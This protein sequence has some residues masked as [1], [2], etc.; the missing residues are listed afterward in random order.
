MC[1]IVGVIAGYS[2]GFTQDE[3][4]IFRDMLFVDTLRGRDSTGVFMVTNKGNVHVR[5]AAVDGPSFIKTDEFTQLRGDSWTKGMFMVGHNRA[6]TRGSINDANA[7][8]FVVDD[9]I[10]LVQN[11]TYFGSHKHHKD[12]EVD[13]EAV[14]HVIAEND[15]IEEALQKVNA[16]YALVWYNVQ[17]STL[18][19]IRNTHRPLYLAKTASDTYVFASESES[20]WYACARASV[21]LKGT[22]KMLE[23][24][25]LHSF[26][27]DAASKTYEHE[28]SK[29]DI[30]FRG[31]GNSWDDEDFYGQ[32]QRH[33][34][35]YAPAN[36][37]ITPITGKNPVA[38]AVDNDLTIYDYV[39][40]RHQFIHYALNDDEVTPIRVK[41]DNNDRTSRIPVELEG[42]L[43]MQSGPN[44]NRWIVYGKMITPSETDPSPLIYTVM[45]DMTE[46]EVLSY[47][48]DDMYTAHKASMSVLHTI[49]P[50]KGDNYQIITQF[51]ANFLPIETIDEVVTNEQKPH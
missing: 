41:L 42:Y 8:P 22:P 20:I 23:P 12:T 25:E 2:N 4:N 7:H 27:F 40:K 47:V 44:C 29:L 50:K 43:P 45:G 6:A 51:C 9:K 5:K 38:K 35:G 24:G 15:N 46:E 26:K 14:A 49:H 18:Y 28:V 16:A 34:G 3:Q 1:G 48:T 36:T 17:T 10:V 33:Y 39:H 31:S 32:W 37:E 21:K 11:G 13:T 30:T 19:L